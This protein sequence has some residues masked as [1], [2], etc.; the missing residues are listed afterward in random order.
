[1]GAKYVTLS[2]CWGS[3]E[4][5]KLERSSLE[6][7]SHEEGHHY[8]FST[9]DISLIQDAIRVTRELGI[10]YLW[11]DSLCI[12]QDSTEDWFTESSRMGDIYSNSYCTISATAAKDS[13]VGL[14]LDRKPPVVY[15][16]LCVRANWDGQV[17]R[18]YYEHTGTLNKKVQVDRDTALWSREIDSAPL[19]NRTWALQERFPRPSQLDVWS[20]LSVLGVCW[21]TCM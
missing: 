3:T 5:K 12:I 20:Q 18:K 2:Y 16:L 7:L 15:P 1:M 4:I 10:R 21:Q 14:F 17:P 13:S 19:N 8:V 11:I 6:D 9:K